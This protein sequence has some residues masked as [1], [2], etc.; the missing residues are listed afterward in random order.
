MHLEA[1]NQVPLDVDAYS[2]QCN[3]ANSFREARALL[4]Q[5]LQEIGYSEA[6]LD[7]RSFRAKNLLGLVPPSDWPGTDGNSDSRQAAARALQETDRAVMEVAQFLNKKKGDAPNRGVTDDSDS[8]D[9]DKMRKGGKDGLDPETVDALGEFSFLKEDKSAA[10]GSAKKRVETGDEWSVNQNAI[11]RMKEKFRSEQERKRSNS[12]SEST[13]PSKSSLHQMFLMGHDD[14]KRDVPADEI[15]QLFGGKSKKEYM[16]INAALGIADETNV[17]IKDEFTA[18]DDDTTAIRWNLK[19]TLRSHFDSIRVM[20]FHPVEPV[21][22]TASED[23]TAKLWNLGATNPKSESAKGAQV[24]S[25]SAAV[26]ELEPTY[27]FRGHN[28]PVL[29][30]DMSPTGDMCYTGGFDGVIC[31]WSVPSVNTDIYDTYDSKVLNEKLKG[32]GDAI[33]SVAYHSSDNRLVSASADGTIRLW[34]PGTTHQPYG[35]GD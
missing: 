33:W 10:S 22:I 8:D 4:R 7:V 29:S 20:Q 23:G 17:D 35:Q 16:D 13:S 9:E 15:Q 21:L 25:P 19:F 6:I 18:P 28:G 30:M 11:N 24:P 2:G 34:E 26:T 12:Q 1:D 31:C 5:Y 32:H 27:T 14:V 3:T